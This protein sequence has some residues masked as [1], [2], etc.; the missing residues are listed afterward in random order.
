MLPVNLMADIFRRDLKQVDV[1]RG[2]QLVHPQERVQFWWSVLK[3]DERL[4]TRG[5]SNQGEGMGTRPK[6]HSSGLGRPTRSGDGAVVPG[7]DGFEDANACGEGSQ[8]LQ[9]DLDSPFLPVGLWVQEQPRSGLDPQP[10]V[11][12]RRNSS[13]R[14]DISPCCASAETLVG[15][16][17]LPLGT[18][19][20]FTFHLL[21]AKVGHDASLGLLKQ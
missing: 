20:P 16:N 14:T 6:K 5:P 12:G 7:N 11:D 18:F 15:R 17:R 9:F 13:A 8:I 21:S 1:A 3:F 10:F 4:G 2:N 19:E